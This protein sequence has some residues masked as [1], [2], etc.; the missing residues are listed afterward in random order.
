[1]NLKK[2]LALLVAALMLFGL[3]PTTFA[4]E[5]ESRTEDLWAEIVAT[6]DAALAFRTRA[7]GFNGAAPTT[8]DFAAIVD[9]LVE[10]VESSSSYRAGTLERHGDFFF[11][12][13]TDGTANG[14]SPRLRANLRSETVNTEAD[15]EAASGIETVSYSRGGSA[16]STSVAVFQPYYGIDSSFTAQYA[17]E[18]K[19]IANALGGTN[20]TY[21]TN[22]AT[23]DN[24]ANAFVNCG[25]IIF[26]S[27]GDTDYANGEDY[28]SRANTSYLCLQS[29]A[30]LTSDDQQAVTGPYGT[31]YHAYY[32]GSY[33]SMKYYCVDGTV[34]ANHMTGTAKNSLLWAAIC[35]GMATDGMHA[36]LRAK[37]V[38]VAYGYSQSVSFTGDYKYEEYFWDYMIAGHTAGE[39]FAYMKQ[40]AGCNWDPAYSNYSTEAAARN[41]RVAFPIMVSS[42]SAYPGHGNVDCVTTP[43]SDWTL[44]PTWEITA[45]SNNNAWGTVSLSS[46]TITA[47]PAVGYYAAGYD[48]VS[49][50]ATVTQNGNL[51]A[52][53]PE[54]DCTIRINF[55]AK[56]PATLS[57]ITPD[58]VSC[59]AINTYVG[60]AVTL[61]A[62]TGTPTADA[63][64]Y[65]F[66]GWA[67]AEADNLTE[68]PGYK[69]AGASI[70]VSGDVTYHA[71]YTYAISDGGAI[72]GYEKVAVDPGDWSGEYVLTYNGAVL[73]DASGNYTGASLGSA[74]AAVAVADA[75]LSLDGDELVGTN[76]NFIYVVEPSTVTVGA[77]T[78]RMKNSSHYISYVGNTNSVSTSTDPSAAS[79]Q[80]Y[81]SFLNG[82]TVSIQNANKTDRYLQYNTTSKIFRCYTNSQK[83]LTL[84]VGATGTR[85]Y[86][87]VL[88]AA[89]AHEHE[90]ALCIG[91]APTCTEDGWIDYLYCAGCGKCFSLEIY[92]ETGELVQISE[93]D[94]V[95][96]ALGHDW[97]EPTYEWSEDNS[98]VTA[99]RVCRT[100][101]EHIETEIAE[102]T[103]KV[104]LAPTAEAEGETTYTAVFENPAFET[105]T[106]VVPIP[107]LEPT[108]P[109][110]EGHDW[111]EPSY[112]WAEDNSAVTATRVCKMNPEHIETEIAKT[113]S[114]V[115]KEATET[116][117]GE[118]LYTATFT[119]PAFAEQTKTVKTPK[120][121]PPVEFTDVPENAYYAES[122][123]WAVANGV[124][125][126]TGATTFSP[127]SACT[128]GQVVTFLW[129]AAGE[130]EPTITENPFNDVNED[131]YFYKAV[132]WAVENGITTGTGEKTFSPGSTCT[133]AQV[134]TF[135]WRAAG[136][137]TDFGDRDDNELPILGANTGFSDVP[138][139][140]YYATAVA[141]AVANDITNG[142]S[143][144]TFSPDKDCTRAHVVTFLYRA[145]SLK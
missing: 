141:W 59:A 1:M 121:V 112:E 53:K 58:G 105:Q 14:Y 12:E 129:R 61:P 68:N 9:G 33:G 37:G 99:T 79:A 64:D 60:D 56:T 38:E 15:P 126:G 97:G 132:L 66:L 89:V 110:A 88:N 103:S 108:D 86:T 25:V 51:F 34:F 100:N 31:Y 118:V 40:K 96:P 128:R 35:L 39:S 139:D 26:D 7:Y 48:V 3:V 13:S 119:N 19:N 138:G 49:G 50:T 73:L 71:L 137:P 114:E 24:I 84:F 142:T 65:R 44:L 145:D 5:A 101:P 124:T 111:G 16:G 67:V 69:A 76:D 22:D 133:R 81:I 57:F 135:L 93:A 6:E 127:Y 2:L 23:V 94:T 11:W 52:V 123:A 46:T 117:E 98:T 125:N 140:A 63:Q 29:G 21:K 70:T 10:L 54:S 92:N 113:T 20:T 109:C 18:G 8:Q 116:E 90:C 27:H 134:V 4:A 74:S 115:I 136:K 75:G 55:A 80:W 107:K 36:P 41:A 91:Q 130:P 122:V 77:Y 144:T 42:E 131:S 102:T 106:K 47:K 32:A 43:K 85:Y 82:G 95:I 72:T 28:T 78:L 30:G 87:T 83:N 45:V 120:L 17:N 104:T 62:P 143:A